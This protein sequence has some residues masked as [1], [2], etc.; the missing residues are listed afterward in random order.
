MT[1]PSS[2]S[3]PL[4]VDLTQRVY[5]GSVDL[6]EAELIARQ[7]GNSTHPGT[8]NLLEYLGILSQRDNDA[9]VKIAADLA[10][11]LGRGLCQ[12]ERHD[13]AIEVFD[14]CAEI[15]R[16]VRA[17][18]KEACCYFLIARIYG[19]Q[20]NSKN[21]IG[22]YKKAENLFDFCDKLL[23]LGSCWDS[24]AQ[25]YIQQGEVADAISSL[26]SAA[27]AFKQ[28]GHPLLNAKCLLSKSSLLY[29]HARIS[30]CLQTLDRA[31]TTIFQIGSTE[32]KLQYLTLRRKCCSYT[33]DSGNAIRLQN[34]ID[35]INEMDSLEEKTTNKAVEDVY[36]SLLALDDRGALLQCEQF[37]SA[38]EPRDVKS[39]S[40]IE[41]LRM[42]AILLSRIGDYLGASSTIGSA[43]EFAANNG[44]S[45]AK[46][47][48]L[49]S[50]ADLHWALGNSTESANNYK[51]ASASSA[52]EVK[53]TFLCKWGSLVAQRTRGDS[54][55]NHQEAMDLFRQAED[56]LRETGDQA[57]LALL[58]FV[59]GET[60]LRNQHDPKAALTFLE[61]GIEL[62]DR[63]LNHYWQTRF[64]L[65]V[66]DAHQKNSKP[67]IAL[68][69]FKD[70]ESLSGHY[71]RR[72]QQAESSKVLCMQ[73]LGLFSTR[74]KRPQTGDTRSVRVRK[75]LLE[76]TPLQEDLLS[77]TIPVEASLQPLLIRYAIQLTD[78]K[79]DH[80][81]AINIIDR[82]FPEI[83]ESQ[84]R[85]N[86]AT[87]QGACYKAIA[88]SRSNRAR[89]ADL[90]ISKPPDLEKV[91]IN[92]RWLWFYTKAIVSAATGDHSVASTAF[93]EAIKQLNEY[94]ESLPP[95]LRLTF[96]RDKSDIFEGLVRYGYER[97]DLALVFET[98]Q[99]LKGR[100]FKDLIEVSASQDHLEPAV[101]TSEI[102]AE[103]VYAWSK[104]SETEEPG[105]NSSD[106]LKEAEINQL[107]L[108]YFEGLIRHWTN[109]LDKH[110]EPDAP[111]TLGELQRS[112]NENDAVCELFSLS[113]KVLLLLI[114]KTELKCFEASITIEELKDVASAVEHWQTI[115]RATASK[116][117]LNAIEELE[118]RGRQSDWHGFG[119][120]LANQLL[121]FTQMENVSH[122]YLVT[123]GLTAVLPIHAM[124]IY[125][126][127]GSPILSDEIN[128]SYLPSASSVTF[129]TGYNTLPEQPTLV[130]FVDP[131]ES[132]PNARIEGQA[133]SNVLNQES[134]AVMSG[135]DA[136][137]K[138]FWDN[139]TEAD[140]LLISTHGNARRLSLFSY[141][142]FNDN[143]LFA[144]E[145]LSQP[146]VLK[147]RPLVLLAA[148][149]SGS[150]DPRVQS[151]GM[152]LMSAFLIAG[153]GSVL[154]T[155]WD[156][157]D[158][159][160]GMAM[161]HF[162]EKMSEDKLNPSA[163][164][165]ET[166]SWLKA[167]K[168]RDIPESWKVKHPS[169]TAF[170]DQ[171]KVLFNHP[172]FWSPFT[173]NGRVNN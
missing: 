89:Q 114:S 146:N 38:C 90:L 164:L 65:I 126:S 82:V 16:K 144:H 173:L 30:E 83:S 132:L 63:V 1:N 147:L 68:S 109:H 104:P 53:A 5:Q 108:E 85:W 99:S 129:L 42:K 105:P 13:N 71:R 62:S 57:S 143:L 120:T 37:L 154:S 34:Q 151:E 67:E 15:Y 36:E 133:I 103:L 171:D 155:L 163:A 119:S 70:A 74:I 48:V 94:R 52:L 142:D 75:A 162:I 168:I 11:A 72:S 79:K 84:I 116:G 54:T 96:F 170:K 14:R 134:S 19:L 27:L 61:E 51:Q 77:G 9:L 7:A 110:N 8:D 141:L 58:F 172:Y 87:Y 167:L 26:E 25:E 20:K 97:G 31:Q 124:P 91:A 2:R 92:Q 117:L 158:F 118:L 6:F 153:A 160:S 139:W 21:A 12:Q 159:C 101:Q 4:L 136:S 113:D 165:S 64:R 18:Y 98:I 22:N 121:Q 76:G 80:Q 47:R 149:Q 3:A 59:M 23:E 17:P 55:R 33:S 125:Q 127:P 131:D 145:V 29:S 106:G 130:A 44:E 152:G 35:R 78:L 49:G 102:R 81:G 46:V 73:Q 88:L 107:E 40:Y 138:A 137:I 50:W 41:I 43:F 161:E 100:T 60:S 128:V 95:A 115:M 156:V 39:A 93:E 32:A 111:V 69:F 122:L 150:I 28:E 112:L 166:A 10:I 123:H 140:V 24:A 148:C 157:D 169:L 66:A 86:D 56:L 45:D 135:S